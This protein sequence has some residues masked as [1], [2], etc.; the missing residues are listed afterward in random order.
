MAEGKKKS[1]LLWGCVGGCAGVFVVFLV[2]LGVG[3]WWFTGAVPV[4]PPETF[5]TED[6]A[7][8]C[9]LEVPKGDS[10]IAGFLVEVLKESPFSQRMQNQGQKQTASGEQLGALGPLHGIVLISPDAGGQLRVGGAIS[11]HRFSRPL[12]K[13]LAA[14]EKPETTYRETAIHSREKALLGI[15]KNNFMWSAGEEQIRTWT[16]RLAAQ[17]QA[18]DGQAGIAASGALK[19]A[20]GRT[21]E[22]RPI[23]FAC[24]NTDGE[25]RRFLGSFAESEPARALLGT[26]IASDPVVS[27]AG[28]A[29]PADKEDLDL[30]V[31]VECSDA[32]T[33]RSVRDG[34]SGAT[35]TLKQTIGL[36]NV[37]A[38]LVGENLVEVLGTLRRVPQRIGRL[39]EGVLPAEVEEQ[40]AE[41]EQQEDAAAE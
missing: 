33:A 22:S 36:E 39:A 15:R 37:R 21:E 40:P 28:D 9:I 30:T 35:E 8:F 14:G 1:K 25:L 32:E 16:D 27:V 29:R 23:R 31:W 4:V 19:E 13:M 18:E 6:A 41:P 5:V 3:V 10:A 34:L 12:G 20:Y 17:R 38:E 7:G 2:L 24:L 11:L 26:G